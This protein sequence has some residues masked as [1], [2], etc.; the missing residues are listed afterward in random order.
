MVLFR[1]FSDPVGAATIRVIRAIRGRISLGSF[2]KCRCAGGWV[3]GHKPP[4]LEGPLQS[5]RGQSCLIVSNRIQ[6]WGGEIGALTERRPSR[7]LSAG[8]PVFPSGRATS[9]FS[10]FCCRQPT[11]SPCHSQ[12]LLL[13]RPPAFAHTGPRR[14]CG[15]LSQLQSKFTISDLR[16]PNSE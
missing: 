13:C 3:G 1:G 8:G 6:S 16:I 15:A 7:K 4:L 2:L 12:P 11:K 5:D 14:F 9:F 10:E